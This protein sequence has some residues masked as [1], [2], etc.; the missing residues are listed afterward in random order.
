MCVCV[1]VCIYIFPFFTYR[2]TEIGGQVT[3]LKSSSIISIRSKPSI[4][5]GPT[6]GAR[7]GPRSPTL[8]P[9]ASPAP[10]GWRHAIQADFAMDSPVFPG[11]TSHLNTLILMPEGISLLTFL[12]IGL[13]SLDALN[14]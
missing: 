10:G 4:R 12:F 14:D 13:G 7:L 8:G 1:C 11:R 3:C 5:I 2:E 9:P 6:G